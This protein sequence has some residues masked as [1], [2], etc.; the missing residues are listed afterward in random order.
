M[1]GCFG[2]ALISLVLTLAVWGADLHDW[3]KPLL[4]FVLACV[5]WMTYAFTTA[6]IEKE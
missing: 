4:A 2:L 5:L 3:K 6:P 1:R